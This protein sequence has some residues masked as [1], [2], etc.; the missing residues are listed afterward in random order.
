MP[1]RGK[2]ED[3]PVVE[4]PPGVEDSGKVDGVITEDGAVPL[5]AEEPSAVQELAPGEMDET[6]QNLGA[7]VAREEG[8]YDLSEDAH[9]TAIGRME[10][11]A[12][13]IDF[14][15]SALV[16][17]TR[18]FLLD[19]IKSRPKPW[20]ACSQAEQR[21]VA[22]A[23]E[24][25][26][27]GLIRQIVETIAA[28]DRL[29][30]RVLLTK[31]TIGDDIQINGK[32]KCI[33]AE[34]E[35]RAV[36]LLHHARGKHVMLTVASVDDYK[37][38]HRAAETEPDEREL[39]FE[40]GEAE[41]PEDDSDLVEAGGSEPGPHEP[42]EATEKVYQTGERETVDGHGVCDIEVNLKTGMVEGVPINDDSRGKVD[43]R[44]ATPAELAA[45]RE[46]V[47]DFEA[48]PVE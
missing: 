15:G 45:E 33:D 32:V 21:D 9:Q 30:V 7:A 17:Q 11:L 3:P 29:P 44:E 26:A 42:V 28:Q 19:V 24:H 20:K 2:K 4:T 16:S 1:P 37:Q 40:S 36:G 41:H 6:L 25:V 8:G 39:P 34:E 10:A 13:A 46:R 47:A 22:A 48:E 18:D 43:I 14:D 38:E 35:D 23:C 27:E 12:D 31:V 5:V